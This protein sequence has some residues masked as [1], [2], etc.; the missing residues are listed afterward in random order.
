MAAAVDDGDQAMAWKTSMV[1]DD[2]TNDFIVTLREGTE[3]R[4]NLFLTDFAHLTAT[5][6]MVGVAL[7]E[8]NWDL[9]LEDRCYQIV[10]APNLN[11]AEILP[12]PTGR[13]KPA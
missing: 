1:W 7:N 6:W 3:I 4:A 10:P 12:F 13:K 2:Q 8:H 11:E 9:P 5:E